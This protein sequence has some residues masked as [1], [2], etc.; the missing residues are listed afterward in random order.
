[1]NNPDKEEEQSTL[2]LFDASLEGYSGVNILLAVHFFIFFDHSHLL[3]PEKGP[4][5]VL[6]VRGA[7]D[8]G[9]GG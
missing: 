6:V 2:C 7:Q 4:G 3:L 1:V 5:R 9:E 8:G